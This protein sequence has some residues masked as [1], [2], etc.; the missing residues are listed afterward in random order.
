MNSLSY[1]DKSN[2]SH[3]FKLVVSRLIGRFSM[4]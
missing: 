2:E 1:V 4:I 3:S